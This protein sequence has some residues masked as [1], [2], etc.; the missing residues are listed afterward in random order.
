MVVPGA[1]FS[2]IRSEEPLILASSC[3]AVWRR[4]SATARACVFESS[5]SF[6]TGFFSGVL[7]VD[8]LMILPSTLISGFAFS[9]F[10]STASGLDFVSRSLAGSGRGLTSAF[11]ATGSEGGVGGCGWGSSN[12]GAAS[13]GFALGFPPPEKGRSVNLSGTTSRTG[14]SESVCFDDKNA[15]PTSRITHSS[16]WSDIEATRNF[17]C[18]RF[19]ACFPGVRNG[20]KP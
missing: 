3:C 5:S 9:C 18:S 8:L 16:P 4:A 20:R 2:L 15:G 1:R 13:G 12:R 14:R 7:F 19:I 11:L 10:L 17:F 6:L